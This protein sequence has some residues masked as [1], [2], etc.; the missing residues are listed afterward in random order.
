[1]GAEGLVMS[2][3]EPQEAFVLNKFADNLGIQI[4]AADLQKG[5]VGPLRSWMLPATSST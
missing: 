3:A 1:M 2:I 5:Q 4:L